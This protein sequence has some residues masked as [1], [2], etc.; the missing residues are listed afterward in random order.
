MWRFLTNMSIAQR[1]MVAAAIT[2]LIPGLVISALGSSYINTLSTINDTVKEGNKAV[3]L[4][5]DIQADLLRMNALLEVL[6]TTP[7]LATSNDTAPSSS[8]A[9]DNVQNTNEIVQLTSDFRA[10]LLT[11]QQG[12]QLSTSASMLNIRETLQNDSQGSQAPN[13]QHTMIYVVNMQWQIYDQSQNQALLD[14]ER[15]DSA[16]TLAADVAQANL[17]Y[18]P[19]K[20]NVDNL[21]GL[22]ENISQ[23]VAQVNAFKI[24][25]ILFWTIAAFLFSTLVVFAVSYLINLTITRPLRQI[26]HLTRR[27][28]QGETTARAVV[29]GHDE[30][31]M[32]AT[33][34]NTM[35]DSIVCLMKNVQCQHDLLEERVKELIGEM[36][37]L[38]AG[39]LRTRAEVTS[40]ALGFLAHSFNCMIDELSTLVIRVKRAT[41]EIEIMSRTAQL[42]IARLLSVS[43]HQVQNMSTAVRAVEEMT[44]RAFT[45]AEQAQ[46]LSAV[47]QETSYL[48]QS[49]RPIFAPAVV[50]EA[51]FGVIEHQTRAIEE[52]ALSLSQQVHYSQSA[53]C[54]LKDAAEAS[55]DTHEHTLEV[56]GVLRKLL[57]STTRLH[58]LVGSFKLREEP[59]IQSLT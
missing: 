15:G 49:E 21:V 40:D 53:L 5:T 28:T 57:K 42:R 39:D 45:L 14:V 37:G 18:L 16:S 43:E 46:V 52:I 35:L 47:A 6:S 33:S 8:I 9:I 31:Y 10:A 36:R 7:N 23:I 4:V 27:I 13:S 26:M 56:D 22:T 20:G 24:Q 38:G 2:A 54:L 44:D 32:V 58:N 50:P 30:T 55:R 29:R 25:P 11:Y 41:G 17:D 12:Y 48:T 34:L 3:K 59:M 51:F 19:L 1:L